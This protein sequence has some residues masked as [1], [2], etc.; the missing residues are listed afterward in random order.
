M[1]R[2]RTTVMFLAGMAATAV[3]G[4]VAVQPPGPAPAVPRPGANSSAAAPAVEPQIVQ[5]PVRE[6]LEAAVPVPSP[7]PAP[8]ASATVRPA[9]PRSVE[10]PR[11]RRRIRL[12]QRRERPAERGSAV[13]VP[14]PR[15]VPVPLVRGGDV[16]ALGTSYGHWPEGSP[17][18]LICEGVYGN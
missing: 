5:G 6:V 12:W 9:A 18:A 11:E 14:L 3:S 15:S 7:G 10:Q 4:C 16:C 1:H 8:H 2:T 13:N 17:Q